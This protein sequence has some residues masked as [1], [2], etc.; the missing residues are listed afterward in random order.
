MKYLAF[1]C[2][3]VAAATVAACAP[4]TEND[5]NVESFKAK[6]GKVDITC[7]NHGSLAVS[8]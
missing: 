5:P 4:K 3:F 6:G 1:F 2:A 8:Y 7:I